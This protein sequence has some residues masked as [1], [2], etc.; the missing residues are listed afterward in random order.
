VNTT[1]L[2]VVVAVAVLVVG[3]ALVL[4][5]RVYLSRRTAALRAHF[6]AEYD[7]V[8]GERGRRL[9]E[10]VLRARQRRRRGLSIR[11]LDPDERARYAAGW[12]AAERDFV[13]TPATALREADLLVTQVMRDRGYPV[14]HFSERADLISV[15]HPDVVQHFRDGH[16]VAVGQEGEDVGT[17]RLRQAMVDY[18]FLFDE[19]LEGG[20]DP[21]SGAGR[22]TSER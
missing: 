11:R 2:I 18:R 15:D 3:I 14:E 13:S 8:V 16:A 4:S 20:A 12:E 19:L 9:G 1:G 22:G 21:V 10:S 5:G 7:R 6:G 17:E